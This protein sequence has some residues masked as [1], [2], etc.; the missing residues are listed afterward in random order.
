MYFL[1]QANSIAPNL[2]HVLRDERVVRSGLVVLCSRDITKRCALV[3][4]SVSPRT[5]GE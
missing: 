1:R 3:V 4:L 5:T 2:T